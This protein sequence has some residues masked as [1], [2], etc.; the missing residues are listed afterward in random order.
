MK[1]LNKIGDC[2]MNCF[3]FVQLMATFGCQASKVSQVLSCFTC[4]QNLC[5]NELFT[6]PL[7]LYSV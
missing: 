4:Q 6:D 3:F 2:V 5:R 1:Y 7:K